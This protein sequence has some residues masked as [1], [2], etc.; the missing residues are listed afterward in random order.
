MRTDD[1]QLKRPDLKG[2]RHHELYI[3]SRERGSFVPLLFRPC[4]KIDMSFQKVLILLL[5]FQGCL[6]LT[7][8]IS[9]AKSFGVKSLWQ[10]C[11]NVIV[12]TTSL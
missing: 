5:F 8:P 2:M 10:V 3:N 12:S 6:S 1:E 4:L 11:K 9:R 7:V